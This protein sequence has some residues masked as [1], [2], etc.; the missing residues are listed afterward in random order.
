MVKD[1]TKRRSVILADRHQNLLEGIRGLLETM[2]D[3]VVM[4]A[5][6]KSLLETIDRMRPDLVVIDL[7]FPITRESNVVLWLRKYDQGLRFIVLSVHDDQTVVARC[8]ASGASG[9]VLKR[10]IATDL[11]PATMEVLQGHAYVSPSLGSSGGTY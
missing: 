11:I 2:F 4:V 3:Y 9:F 8:M 6:E 7:S 5:D 10:S 1:D